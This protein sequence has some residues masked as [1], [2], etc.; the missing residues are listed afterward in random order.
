M[1]DKFDAYKY[2]WLR[3][4]ILKEDNF[5]YV[6][7]PYLKFIL[8]RKIQ[9]KYLILT[10]CHFFL[11]FIINRNVALIFSAR[12]SSSLASLYF[13]NTT[14]QQHRR[15]FNRSVTEVITLA[16]YDTEERKT[17]KNCPTVE[18]L[19]MCGRGNHAF[20]GRFL[21][22]THGSVMP[23]CQHSHPT[24]R[25]IS[26]EWDRWKMRKRLMEN[27]VK[28]VPYF[29]RTTKRIHFYELFNRKQM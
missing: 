13:R 24:D 8:F 25:A 16:D 7:L 14:Q 1:K 3:S 9:L 28:I 26:G 29:I 5:V 15:K 17:S 11:L 22:D 19:Q 23:A 18:D 6:N 20:N 27:D 21:F 12:R 4:N 10:N 2:C